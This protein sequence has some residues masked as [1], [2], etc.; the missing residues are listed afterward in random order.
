MTDTASFDPY[1]AE[2]RRYFANPVHAG[3]LQGDYTESAVEQRAES[4]GGARL[5]LAAG[6]RGGLI[7][8][9]RFRACGCPH[10]IAAAEW[11]CGKMEGQPAAAIAQ[12]DVADCM[13]QLAVPV[14]KT[15]RILLLEDT[16]RSLS[17]QLQLRPNAD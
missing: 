1:S 10:T 11:W 9:C 7:A 6:L 5:Q 12:F 16:I 15:G 8:E 2:T 4:A 13:R 17:G 3:D 14:E